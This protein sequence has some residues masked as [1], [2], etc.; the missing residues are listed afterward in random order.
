MKIRPQSLTVPIS[1]H[2]RVPMHIFPQPIR[3]ERE[4]DQRIKRGEMEICEGKARHYPMQ[5]S[6]G[7]GETEG[8]LVFK[9]AS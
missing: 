5:T 9:T 8:K 6:L 3:G 1:H 2:A 7:S 4:A